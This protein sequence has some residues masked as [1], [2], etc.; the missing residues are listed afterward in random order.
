MPDNIR[1][2]LDGNP[3]TTLRNFNEPATKS[4]STSPDTSSQNSTNYFPNQ[5]SSNKDDYFDLRVL[6][7]LLI[8]L[9]VFPGGTLAVTIYEEGWERG[10][11][12]LRESLPDAKIFAEREGLRKEE[13][14]LGNT[15]PTAFEPGAK[16]QPCGKCVL[17]DQKKELAEKL[18]ALDMEEL[19]HLRQ[20]AKVLE[21]KLDK[22]KVS[23]KT[24]RAREIAHEDGC[25]AHDEPDSK[26]GGSPKTKTRSNPS[27][28]VFFSW[29]P[30]ANNDATNEEKN[31]TQAKK[32]QKS[33]ERELKAES[34]ARKK[35]ERELAAQGENREKRAEEVK[36]LEA[37][38]ISPVGLALGLVLGSTLVFGYSLAMTLCGQDKDPKT[39]WTQEEDV[40]AQG[41]D[42]KKRQRVCEAQGEDC[43]TC[44]QELNA[45]EDGRSSPFAMSIALGSTLAVG[46][47]AIAASCR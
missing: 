40:E 12:D 21:G 30:S 4:D 16:S 20:R 43:K 47:V 14:K 38:Q 36:G 29:G 15:V 6:A 9:V 35:R 26:V 32:A 34:E 17:R 42:S 22:K 39:W 7:Y 24:D 10:A 41:K 2:I 23:I 46:I 28:I 11:Q 3:A 45:P 27:S 37:S 8:V 25:T 31:Q 1:L 33:R 13:E 18:E 44:V 19:K 5:S